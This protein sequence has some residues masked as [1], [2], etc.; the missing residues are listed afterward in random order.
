MNITLQDNGKKIEV[1][2]TLFGESRNNDLVHQLLTAYQAGLRKGTKAQKNRAAVTCSG[3]KPHK[4]KGTGRARAGTKASPLWRSGGVTFAQRDVRDYGQKINKKMYKKALRIILSQLKKDNR[5]VVISELA[6]DVCK[7]K[8][9]LSFCKDI[10]FESGLIVTDSKN[11]DE[12]ASRN[13]YLSSRNLKG[14]VHAYDN[15]IDPVS[16]LKAKKV[17]ITQAALKNI[18]ERLV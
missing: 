8:L 4:Q 16:L 6:L 5:I 11:N 17:C 12:A 13:I 14:I 15:Q 3:V 2:D 10:G 9:M 1:S 7:T 18:E